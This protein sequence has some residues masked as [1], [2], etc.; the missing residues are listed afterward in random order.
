MIAQK[1]EITIRDIEQ[2]LNI[3]G[4]NAYYHL[5]MMLRVGMV[6]TRNRGRTLLYSLSP[7][8]FNS[9]INAL[10]QYTKPK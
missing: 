4:T 6:Q 10:S 9:V 5:S 8:Y 7:E 3:A 1:G 2:E